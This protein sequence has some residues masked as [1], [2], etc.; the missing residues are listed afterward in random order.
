MKEEEI[1]IRKFKLYFEDL[2]EATQHYFCIHFKTTLEEESL[3]STP[4]AVV[5]RR[6]EVKEK[7]ES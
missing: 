2:S 5:E 4:I 3:H 7:E 1:E 6:M